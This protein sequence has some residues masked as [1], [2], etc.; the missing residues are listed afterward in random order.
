MNKQETCT[1][2]I[3]QRITP[4]MHKQLMAIAKKQNRTLSSYIKTLF[5]KAIK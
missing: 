5:I 2:K 3:S 4:K 1:N